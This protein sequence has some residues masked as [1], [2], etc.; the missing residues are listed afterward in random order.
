MC[1]YTYRYIHIC[2]LYA[3]GFDL[4]YADFDRRSAAHVAATR[5]HVKVLQYLAKRGVDMSATDRRASS[6][7]CIGISGM[8]GSSTPNSAMCFVS[9]SE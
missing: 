7:L 5:G 6:L 4:S 8:E 9:V 1:I 2:C 3:L